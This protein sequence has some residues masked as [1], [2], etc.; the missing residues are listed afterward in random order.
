LAGV[1]AK[2]HT[3]AHIYTA[4]NEYALLPMTAFATIN[5]SDCY[6]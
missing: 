6:H 2:S 5:D 1:V 4:K 3:R